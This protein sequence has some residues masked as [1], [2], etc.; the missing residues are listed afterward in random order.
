MSGQGKLFDGEAKDYFFIGGKLKHDL[1]A[2]SAQVKAHRIADYAVQAA[3]EEGITNQ[4]FLNQ[5]RTLLIRM[6]WRKN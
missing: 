3:R 6:P 5:L 1:N 4:E 2:E